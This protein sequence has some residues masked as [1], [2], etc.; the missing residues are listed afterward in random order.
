MYTAV[1]YPWMFRGIILENTFTSMGDMVDKVMF[2]AK[3]F[4]G[5]ILNSHWNSIDIVD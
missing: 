1:K 5:L 2:F 3:H 4:K